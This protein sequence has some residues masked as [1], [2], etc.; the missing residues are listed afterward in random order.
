MMRSDNGALSAHAGRGSIDAAASSSDEYR[1]VLP[2]FPDGK[3][4]NTNKEK[5]MCLNSVFLHADLMRRPYHAVDFRDGLKDIVDMT[6]VVSIGQFQM[7]H[8]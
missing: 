2:R 6:D 8:I 1:V 5:K 7:S 4:G 3:R